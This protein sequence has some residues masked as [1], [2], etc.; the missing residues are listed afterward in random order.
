MPT[1]EDHPE[2]VLQRLFDAF[3][4]ERWDEYPEIVA[5]DIV[6]HE[7]GEEIRGL[8]EQLAF[9]KE[10]KQ[11]HPDAAVDVEEMATSGNTVFSRGIAPDGGTHLLCAHVEDGRISEFWVLSE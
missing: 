5:H 6:A 8:A 10:V 4:N 9:E 2:A 7:N 3:A 1:D 11:S